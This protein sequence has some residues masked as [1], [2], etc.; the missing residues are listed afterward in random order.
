ML[1][2]SSQNASPT[3]TKTFSH[4]DFFSSF[5]LFPAQP[6]DVLVRCVFVQRAR[7]LS[8]DSSHVDASPFAAA[9]NRTKLPANL[10]KFRL[11][12]P[13]GQGD[14]LEEVLQTEEILISST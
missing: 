1:T 11:S 3:G 13:S 4:V 6:A 8:F 12:L 2:R 14:F 9:P 10:T 5:L 7:P